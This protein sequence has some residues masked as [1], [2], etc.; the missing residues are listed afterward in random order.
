MPARVFREEEKREIKKKLLDIGFPML[1]EYGLVH[2]SIPK[3]AKEAGIGTG[4]F[5]R[6][7]QSK[8]EYIYQ[9]IQYRREILLS[10][11]VTE[12]IKGGK[13]KL[14]KD[15]VRHMIQLLVDKDKSV[16][17]NLN[18]KD[19]VKLLKYMQEF[20]PNI[21]KEKQITEKLLGWIEKPKEEI[22]FP[23]LANLM[24]SLVLIAQAREEL[25]QEG[26]E[27]TISLLIDTILN[28]IYGFEGGRER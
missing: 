14:S 25:H 24:K 23:V 11:V 16:Y 8:E 6:F 18:L 19:E 10:E 27:R 9:L 1:K 22:D 5:Y 3:I 21:Q 26:Y 12:D 7:F 13:R 20:S 2:M 17:A 4:T 15:E 28:E